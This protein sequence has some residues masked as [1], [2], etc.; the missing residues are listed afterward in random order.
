MQ[1]ILYIVSILCSVIG[2]MLFGYS[3][4]DL[5][6]AN[7]KTFTITLLIVAGVFILIAFLFALLSALINFNPKKIQNRTRKNK[8]FTLTEDEVRE[9]IKFIL[10]N[11]KFYPVQYGNE[12]VY[13]NG[14]GIF[15]TRKF[16]KIIFN[17]KKIIVEGWISVG[18]FSRPNLENNL[19]PTF[20]SKRPKQVTLDV[21]DKVLSELY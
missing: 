18:I 19:N 8:N 16:I 7:T 3:L 6:F 5:L 9:K 15:A 17:E 20:F 21:M 10:A 12:N 1:K 4:V 11:Q 13:Q 14:K 2:G